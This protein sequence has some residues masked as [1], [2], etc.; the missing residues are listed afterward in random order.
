MENRL[1]TLLSQNAE[2]LPFFKGSA[3]AE[4]LRTGISN[5]AVKVASQNKPYIVKFAIAPASRQ[6]VF[7]QANY[8][9]RLES[10]IKKL[11]ITPEVYSFGIVTIAGQKFPYSIQQFLEGR[12]LDYG[13]DLGL[14]AASMH[15]LHSKTHGKS[16]IC[17][18]KVLRPAEY[19]LRHS[20]EDSCNVKLEALAKFTS[21][22]SGRLI[23]N[24]PEKD[25]LCLIHNDLTPENVLISN[26][27]A[28]PIDWGWA[29][30]SSAAFDLCNAISPFTTSWEKKYFLS[31]RQIEKFLG[32]YF[33]KYPNPD[34]KV[35]LDSLAAYWPA[36]NSLIGNWIYNEFLGE[37]APKHRMHLLG[38][39]FIESALAY[40]KKIHPLLEKM[41]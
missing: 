1:P 12:E 36:Y 8:E 6:T 21:Y 22:A 37:H 19:L 35:I 7:I 33:K 11:K 16:N 34:R 10:R 14:L 17:D 27:R 24:K 9:K 4:L 26:G 13:K 20:R 15:I 18:Y 23:E 31:G 32:A 3:S 25:Y 41:E 40:I 38:K 39:G 28:M 30:Y 5:V 29:M 2:R